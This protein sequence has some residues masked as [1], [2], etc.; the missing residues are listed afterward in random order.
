MNERRTDDPQI[1]QIDDLPSQPV[2]GRD[3]EQVKGGFNPQ[4]DPPGKIMPVFQPPVFQLPVLKP[5]GYA[6]P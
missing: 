4:P 3:A 2:D 6:Q 5:G 1:E